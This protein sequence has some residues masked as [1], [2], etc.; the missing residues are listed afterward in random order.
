MLVAG[1]SAQSMEYLFAYIPYRWSGNKTMLSQPRYKNIY[2]SKLPQFHAVLPGTE[3][4]F[5]PQV[6]P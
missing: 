5:C 4:K 2:W 6:T 1:A 3:S